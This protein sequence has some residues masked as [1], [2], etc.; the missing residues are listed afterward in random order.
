MVQSTF[1]ARRIPHL[2]DIDHPIRFSLIHINKT[3]LLIFAPPPAT[4]PFAH[5]TTLFGYQLP[6]WIGRIDAVVS[7]WARPQTKHAT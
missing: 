4:S 3:K 2:G 5:D 6:A 7:A 1:G